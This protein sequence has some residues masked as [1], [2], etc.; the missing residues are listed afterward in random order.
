[1]AAERKERVVIEVGGRIGGTETRRI[2]DI[3]SSP[4]LCPSGDTIELEES[5]TAGGRLRTL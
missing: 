4:S 1:M 5:E 3:A 2:G